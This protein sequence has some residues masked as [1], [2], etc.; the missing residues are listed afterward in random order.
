MSVSPPSPQRQTPQR[1]SKSDQA[2]VVF[3]DPA[4][5]HRSEV[6]EDLAADFDPEETAEVLDRRAHLARA[7]TVPAHMIA[8]VVDSAAAA[9]DERSPPPPFRERQPSAP[10]WLDEGDSEVVHPDAPGV[11]AEVHLEKEPDTSDIS[12]AFSKASP[13]PPPEAAAAAAESSQASIPTGTVC[14]LP[15]P[16]TLP[17]FRPSH[18]RSH[19][20]L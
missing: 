4:P 2:H 6:V 11:A 15:S 5:V 7:N 9:D 3:P 10:D 1:T 14:P 16:S 17:P 20:P 18:A 19:D 13:S 12:I 8:E